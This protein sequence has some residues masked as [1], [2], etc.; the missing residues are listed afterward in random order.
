[1]VI[2]DCFFMTAAAFKP[3]FKRLDIEVQAFKNCSAGEMVE[4]VPELLGFAY[5]LVDPYMG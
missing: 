4:E 2:V 3:C 5:I 1:M